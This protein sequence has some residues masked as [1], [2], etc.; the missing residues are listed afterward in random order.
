MPNEKKIILSVEDLTLRL[1]ET[2]T[3]IDYGSFDIEDDDFVIIKGNNGSG[4][5]TFLKLFAP[6]KLTGYCGL[7][8]G[9]MFY[10]DAGLETS[11]VFSRGY[12]RAKLLRRVVNITQEEKFSSSH[13]G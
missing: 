12:D 11:D 2:K 7:V 9:K 5:S 10:L 6:T 13:D 4:K 3:D 1:L 8:R